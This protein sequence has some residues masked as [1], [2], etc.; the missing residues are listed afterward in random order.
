MLDMCRV[1]GLLGD[2]F[3]RQNMSVSRV[4]SAL[5]SL[6]PCDRFALLLADHE[7]FL[8]SVP[9]V[10]TIA[11]MIGIAP[12]LEGATTLLPCRTRCTLP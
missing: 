9:L 2:V 1:M 11:T 4:H 6:I 8:L 3:N 10:V 5:S 7:L 12:G